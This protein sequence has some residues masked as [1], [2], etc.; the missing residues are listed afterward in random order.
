ML[1]PPQ[2]AAAFLITLSLCSCCPHGRNKVHI[3][4]ID[5]NRCG[6]C[7]RTMVSGTGNRL[8]KYQHKNCPVGG[9]LLIP[10]RFC[11][12]SAWGTDIFCSGQ[13]EKYLFISTIVRSSKPIPTHWDQI[14]N[15]P[16]FYTKLS[17]LE[18]NCKEPSSL[19]I[20][21]LWVTSATLQKRF[22]VT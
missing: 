14:P 9:K 17:L 3:L 13:Q 2:H 19:A 15:M 21:M 1:L 18:D 16:L 6:P 12:H 20:I 4:P 7:W 10:H 22:Y 8:H 11:L 5:W